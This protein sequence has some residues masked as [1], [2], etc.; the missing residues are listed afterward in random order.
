V[1]FSLSPG[2]AKSIINFAMTNVKVIA[3]D[4]DGTLFY[5]RK[6]VRMIPKKSREFIERFIKDGG[7][8]L[9]VSGRNR[10]ISG[11]VTRNLGHQIDVVG[12]N[13]AFI[14]SGGA[15]VKETFFDKEYLKK[16]LA[17]INREYDPPLV[18]LLTKRRNLVMT[19]TDVSHFTNFGYF[20]Y[21]LSQGVYKEPFI[22]SDRVFY[23]ELAFG[24][25]YKV[26]IMFGLSR[27]KRLG[28]KEANKLFRLRYP[29]AEFSWIGEFIEIT[30]GGCSKSN[31]IAFYLDYNKIPHDNVLVVGD[32]GNDISM[33]EAFHEQSFCMD[34]GPEEVKKHASHVIKRFYDLASYIY[35]SEENSKVSDQ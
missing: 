25:V 35:P 18:L 27:K 29:E 21:E 15:I 23:E 8:L 31:G 5:P 32:S 10:Y 34:H 16:I 7:K 9:L 24:Q 30:P 1:P 17:D 26:M 12:C 19:Q 4:L 28:A 22:R 14:T 20:L 6:R 33:F 2:R 11:K 13:G 3:T